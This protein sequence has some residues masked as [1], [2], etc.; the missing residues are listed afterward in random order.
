M[1]K[2][3]IGAV[4]LCNLENFGIEFGFLPIPS[5]ANCPIVLS[6]GTKM[7]KYNLNKDTSSDKKVIE[8]IKNNF[9]FSADHRYI[10]GAYGAKL[11]GEFTSLIENP[12]D[13]LLFSN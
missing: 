13:K 7:I 8:E 11:Q 12:D 5:T 6:I 10:D 9:N 4:I 2:Y 1:P 3:S